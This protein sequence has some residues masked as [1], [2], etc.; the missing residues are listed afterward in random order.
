VSGRTA[1]EI[2]AELRRWIIAQNSAASTMD[3]DTDIVESRLVD[4]LAFINFLLL[5]EELRGAEIPEEQV[6][7]ERFRT[8][9][10]IQTNFLC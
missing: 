10:T 1:E 2:L 4:S 3:L 9:R 6:D 8:L 5:L 7:A